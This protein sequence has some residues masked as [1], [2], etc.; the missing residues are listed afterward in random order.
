MI[1]L[2]QS[3]LNCWFFFFYCLFLVGT[4]G[5]IFHSPFPDHLLRSPSSN[6]DMTHSPIATD[7]SSSSGVQRTC[8][9]VATLLLASPSSTL[10]SSYTPTR[11]KL[12]FS[13]QTN[14]D[15]GSTC[16]ISKQW[17]I[18]AELEFRKIF[19]V[20]NYI[21]RFVGFFLKVFDFC[22]YGLQFCC[23]C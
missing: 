14:T 18:L 11:K 2:L 23:N 3:F 16:T 17:L 21:G 9:R 19:L 1:G 6:V 20:L 12:V 22:L 5:F 10:G 13:P 7:G 4:D 8:N 15:R